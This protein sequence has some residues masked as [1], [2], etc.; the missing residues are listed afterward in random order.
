MSL[1]NLADEKVWLDQDDIVLIET[2][3]ETLYHMPEL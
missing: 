1:K 3:S 2:L